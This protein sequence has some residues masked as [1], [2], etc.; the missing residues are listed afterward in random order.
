M[1]SERQ[2]EK[3]DKNCKREKNLECISLCYNIMLLYYCPRQYYLIPLP[4][5]C[6]QLCGP[7]ESIRNYCI[8]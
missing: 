6:T 5:Q 3:Y 4:I 8:N 1:S 2:L 7:R